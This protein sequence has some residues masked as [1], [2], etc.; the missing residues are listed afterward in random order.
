MPLN[1]SFRTP[2][3][4]EGGRGEGKKRKGRLSFD[5]STV[6]RKQQPKRAREK[7]T[8]VEEDEEETPYEHKH[9]VVLRVT[10][11]VPKCNS[12]GKFSLQLLAN[13]AKEF[14]ERDPTM[15]YHCWKDGSKAGNLAEL[16]DK[17]VAF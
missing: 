9:E 7:E 16:P 10:M 8:A 11:R 4:K 17:W 1:K 2:A 12:P 15:V 3:T 13:G 5:P 6:F 14:Q